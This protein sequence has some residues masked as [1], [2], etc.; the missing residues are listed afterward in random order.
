MEISDLRISF[1]HLID[2]ES[3]DGKSKSS[4]YMEKS[5]K[6]AEILNRN[7]VHEQIDYLITNSK[8]IENKYY[9]AKLFITEFLGYWTV[10]GVTL[11]L[12]SWVCL[13]T[14]SASAP[15]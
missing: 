6:Y 8:N 15:A 7:I 9:Q 4:I 3:D 10:I 12:L 5:K 1:R 11:A 13:G 14:F 2:N